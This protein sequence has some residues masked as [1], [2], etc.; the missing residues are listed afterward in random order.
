MAL[1]EDLRSELFR[2]RARPAIGGQAAH[3]GRGA[4]DAGQKRFLWNGQCRS[5]F[6]IRI[7]HRNL[8]VE[9]LLLAH[10]DALP[11]DGRAS[12]SA[13]SGN[14]AIITPMRRFP[15]PW[16][17]DEANDACFIARDSTGK[18][19]FAEPPLYAIR[20]NVR[21]VL[22]IC[23]RCAL[24]GAALSIRMSQNILAA[25]LVVQRVEAIVGFCLRF[26]V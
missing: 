6:W 17:L 21:K 13:Q 20:L 8:V 14:G 18:R 2:G 11:H 24:V 22:T 23:P 16:T 1:P 5:G 4:A 9:C 12:L 10:S 3:Q 7:G 25:D 26:R 19:Q 15:P